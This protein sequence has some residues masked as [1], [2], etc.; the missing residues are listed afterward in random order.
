MLLKYGRNKITYI[1][2]RFGKND[3][4]HNI[5]VDICVVYHIVPNVIS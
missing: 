2:I 3:I 5:L 4:M 1:W